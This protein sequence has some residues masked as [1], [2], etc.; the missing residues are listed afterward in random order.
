MYLILFIFCIIICK[1]I[2]IILIYQIFTEFIYLKVQCVYLFRHRA[3][4]QI[5]LNYFYKVNY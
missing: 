4:Y 2:K 5:S 1:S 3:I